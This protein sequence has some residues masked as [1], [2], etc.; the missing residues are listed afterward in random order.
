MSEEFERM[1]QSQIAKRKMLAEWRN[2]RF[3]EVELPSGL[4]VKVR[5][6]DITDL[7]LSGRVPNTLMGV[8][9]QAAEGEQVNENIVSEAL[10]EHAEAFGQLL[11]AMVQ[12]ALVEPR[13]GDTA[14]DE[15]ITLAEIPSSDKLFLFNFMNRETQA[16][17][18]FR[19]GQKE[20]DRSA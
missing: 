19:D 14:D 17:R 18:S 1:N 16:V 10:T 20:F 3:H 4:L 5:D 2:G 11:D 6:V 9:S 12:A 15:H 8:L 13:I 7:A